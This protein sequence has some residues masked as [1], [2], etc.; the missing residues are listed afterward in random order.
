[1]VSLSPDDYDREISRALSAGRD[2]SREVKITH[3]FSATGSEPLPT[4]ALL[5]AEGMDEIIVD[6]ELAGD[7]FWHIAAFTTLLLSP[8]NANDAQDAMERIAQNTGV[9]YDGWRVTLNVA[10]ET[11]YRA[12]D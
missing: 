10:E 5:E 3:F 8:A 9:R 7:G 11:H 2:L 4:R 12:S 6:E 1:M